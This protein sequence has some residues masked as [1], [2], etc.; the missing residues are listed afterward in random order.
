MI[1]SRE[2]S[3]LC[4]QIILSPARLLTV[5]VVSRLPEEPSRPA[6]PAALHQQG[7]LH[8]VGQRQEFR[9]VPS[10]VISL[11][12]TIKTENVIL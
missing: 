12:R 2:Q 11:V 7:Q 8:R 6:V 9:H 3:Y 10:I 5:H 4:Y 1:D